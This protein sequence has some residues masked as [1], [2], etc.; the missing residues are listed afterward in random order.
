MNNSI[1][2]ERRHDEFVSAVAHNHLPRIFSRLGIPNYRVVA[3]S[4]SPSR[5]NFPSPDIAVLYVN[6]SW[7]IVLIE[8]KS[9]GRKGR[10]ASLEN[11]LMRLKRLSRYH[12]RRELQYMVQAPFEVV[13]SC[14]VGIVGVYQDINGRF[15][16]HHAE[17]VY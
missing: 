14:R 1:Q 6:G 12:D 11:Q 9:T 8:A 3:Q 10:L 7:G 16:I 13:K 2:Q 15:Q 17:N 5:K 4:F